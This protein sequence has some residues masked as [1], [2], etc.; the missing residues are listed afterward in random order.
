M[1]QHH[2]DRHPVQRRRKRGF[3]PKCSDLAEQLKKRFLRQIFGFLSIRGHAQA[4]GVNA[5]L[6]QVIER[7]ESFRV[8]LL[9]PLNRLCFA[10]PVA[11]LPSVGQNSLY[12][13][14]S[15][16]CGISVFTLYWLRVISEAS[17]SHFPYPE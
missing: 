12:W 10:E 11:L 13:P 2:I 3:A 1:H 8:A 6:V 14:Q 7:L 17:K 4:E 9:R 15:V 16:G 5:T